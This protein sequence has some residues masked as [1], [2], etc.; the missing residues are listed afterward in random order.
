ME[1][2]YLK[3]IVGSP[4]KGKSVY[5]KDDIYLLSKSKQL[6]YG[7]VICPTIYNGLYDYIPEDFRHAQFDEKII[8]NLMKGQK[9]L[10]ELDIEKNA[11]I[12]FDDCIGNAEWNTKVM[13]ELITTYRHLRITVIIASQY[14]KSVPPLIRSCASHAV[15]FKPPNEISYKAML[16]SFFQDFNTVDELKQYFDQ[17]VDKYEAVEV[18]CDE[19][20][21]NG[22]YQIVKATMRDFSL[23]Y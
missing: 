7:I 9:K 1:T 22:R 12:I 20:K 16:E 14:C 19:D 15:I 6:N 10:R 3:Y 11:F 2:P 13:K 5:I 23:R 8:H 4:K 21:E 17:N 18:H